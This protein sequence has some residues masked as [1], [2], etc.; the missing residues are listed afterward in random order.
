M[1]GG[2]W[3]DFFSLLFPECCVA[4]QTDL[5]R[6][7]DFVCTLCAFHMP[8]THFHRYLDNNSA[9]QLWGR[10]PFDAVTSFLFFAEKSRVE[11]IIYHLKYLNKPRLAHKLGQAYGN[12]LFEFGWQPGADFLVPVPL[13]PKKHKKRGYNQSEAF[14]NGLANTWGVPVRN[15]VLLRRDDQGS[16]TGRNR[17]DRSRSLSTAMSLKTS[18]G[19]EG[20]HLVLVDDVL[21]TGATLEACASELIKIPG[22]RLSAVTIARKI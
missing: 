4:C 8:Y 2:V 7:E 15:D 9:K 5:V 19:L 18:D 17:L 1:W 12:I 22:V 3:K 14:A 21:T 16:Q 13:H 6:G 11:R 20:K 10:I